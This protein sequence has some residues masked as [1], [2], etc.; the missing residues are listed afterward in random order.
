M[1]ISFQLYSAR[2]F[3]SLD[4]LLIN[5]KTF[6]YSYVEGY[7]GLFEDI[8]AL[9]QALRSSRLSMPA[10]HFDLATLRDTE[11]TRAIATQL[12]ATLLVCPW[13][14]PDAR[15]KTASDWREFAGELEQLASA[16]AKHGLSLAWHN[17]DFEFSLLS[18]GEIPM[19]ILLKN[20]PNIDWQF[21]VA[22]SVRAGHNPLEWIKNHGKRI[23]SVH[24]KDIAPA[25][26]CA[27]E[28]GWADVGHG[29]MDWAGIFA[30]LN[31]YSSCKSFVVEH[32]NPKDVIRFATRSIATVQKLRGAL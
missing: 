4:E 13:L 29:I 14:E 25:G 24:V 9:R 3:P 10:S 15:P 19:D 1:G 7:G 30:T 5:L 11:K 28:D 27:D 2:S 20:A 22:W 31:Q 6:K 32:D 12:N 8:S 26:E 21:D 16:Y 23:V 18:T 17:H